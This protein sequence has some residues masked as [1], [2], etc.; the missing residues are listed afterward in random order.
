MHHILII[1]SVCI[2]AA[3][4]Q[5]SLAQGTKADYERAARLVQKTKGK[6]FKDRV[7]SQW[8]ADGDRFWYQNK[9]AGGASEFVFVDANT[10]TR[11]PAFDH[12]KLAAALTK[13]LGRDIDANNLPIKAIELTA[14]GKILISAAGATFSFDPKTTDLADREKTLSKPTKGGKLGQGTR[15]RHARQ[16]GTSPDG[17]WKI[18][19][20]EGNLVGGAKGGEKKLPLTKDEK[21]EHVGI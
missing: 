19:V 10:G 7:D 12:T 4:S 15:Q 3:A 6:V 20:V 14:D 1:A 16:G 5:S 18:R 13:K 11:R 2:V 9:L 17:A 21:F 8:L